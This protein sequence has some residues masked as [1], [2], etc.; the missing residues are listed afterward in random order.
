MWAERTVDKAAGYHLD[1]ASLLG[2]VLAAL[3]WCFSDEGDAAFGVQLVAAAAP[4]LIG[5]SLLDKCRRW[6]ERAIEM[7]DETQVGTKVEM[8]LQGALGHSLMLT[9]SNRERAGMALERAREIAIKLGDLHNRFRI[10]G[11][12][13]L[14]CRRTGEVSRSLAIALEMQSV[15]AE[16][17]D[18]IARAGAEELL[19]FSHHMAGDQAK[20]RSSFE[21]SLAQSG[22]V[23]PVDPGHFAFYHSPCLGLSRGLWV[24]GHADEAIK[25][26]RDLVVAPLSDVDPV[27]SCISLIFAANIHGWAG[28]W[29]TVEQLAERLSAHAEEHFLVPYRNVGLGLKAEML[30]QRG[31][32]EEG[33]SLLQ[34]SIAHLEAN[35]YQLYTPGFRA[36]LAMGLASSG[37]IEEAARDI[38]GA[39]AAVEGL[40]MLFILPEL[41]RT[42]G[43][44]CARQND[45]RQAQSL[46]ERAF[47]MAEQQAALSWRLRVAM[48]MLRLATQGGRAATARK[49][50]ADTYGRFTEGFAT[51]DLQAAKQLLENTAHARL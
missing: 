18:P 24:Q 38:D 1:R 11:R 51:A 16:I 2:N 42:K 13:H 47:A 46:F 20:A 40:G 43:E 4:Y 15:A 30:I 12:L 27:S 23:R 41:L 19:G 21:T 29:A 34:R 17:N 9:S 8:E 50:L 32:L 45:A 22:D 35:R 3:E 44:L 6:T 7:I 37:Q 39:I 26:A 28:D 33:I 5:I 36:T 25:I 31:Q 14:Y 10:L 48:S 49:L